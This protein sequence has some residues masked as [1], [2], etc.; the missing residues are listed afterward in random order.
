MEGRILQPKSDIQRFDQRYKSQGLFKII[1]QVNNKF[2][3]RKDSK[4]S[5]PIKGQEKDKGFQAKL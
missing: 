4:G 5:L 1:F 3:R 2:K